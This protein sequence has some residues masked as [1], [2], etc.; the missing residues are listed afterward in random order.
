MN[1]KKEMHNKGQPRYQEYWSVFRKRKW[2]AAYPLA[3]KGDPFKEQ[4]YTGD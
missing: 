3:E 1:M 2:H 4:R